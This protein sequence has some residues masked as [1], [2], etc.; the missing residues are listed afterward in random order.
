MV[1][2][3]NEW[4]YYQPG[5]IGRLVSR[6][7]GRPPA[8]SSTLYRNFEFNEDT[9]RGLEKILTHDFGRTGIDFGPKVEDRTDRIYEYT[10]KSNGLDIFLS[11][12]LSKPPLWGYISINGI[13]GTN[14]EAAV[15]LAGKIDKIVKEYTGDVPGK[16]LMP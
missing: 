15:R 13:N 9:V 11:G 1:S 7:A 10:I 4:R 2:N 3:V 5:R 12:Q 8:P 16:W 14:R 6:K